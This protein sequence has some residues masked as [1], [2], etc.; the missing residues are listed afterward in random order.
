MAMAFPANLVLTLSTLLES[1]G[2]STKEDLVK[3][4]LGLIYDWPVQRNQCFSWSEK[5]KKREK[6]KESRVTTTAVVVVVVAAAAAAAA[7]LIPALAPAPASE[8]QQQQLR[9][10]V[11]L[12]RLTERGNIQGYSK[13]IPYTCFGNTAK[14]ETLA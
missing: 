5:E 4:E 2:R 6:E 3:E 1:Y 13:I 9:A 8:H 10:F 12:T 7:A 14:H 11:A